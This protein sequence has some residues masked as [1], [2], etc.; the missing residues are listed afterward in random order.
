MGPRT[1]F[2]YQ[3][4]YHYCCCCRCFLH[5]IDIVAFF[6][7]YHYKTQAQGMF[8]PRWSWEE[9]QYYGETPLKAGN[10]YHHFILATSIF[11]HYSRFLVWNSCRNLDF[12][13][14][15]CGR[16]GLINPFIQVFTKNR[17]KFFHFMTGKWVKRSNRLFFLA[18]INVHLL[19]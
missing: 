18:G 2:L 15:L 8:P 5:A 16:E 6:F 14:W 1:C 17:T 11:Y 10:S 13:S 12:I 3:C 9:P 7:F 4:N 19:N